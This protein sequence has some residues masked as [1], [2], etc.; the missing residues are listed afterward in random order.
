MFVLAGKK[1]SQIVC[2]SVIGNDYLYKYVYGGLYANLCV[3]TRVFK[4]GGCVYAYVCFIWNWVVGM[5]RA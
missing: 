1:A 4:G 3:G 2:V 5:R